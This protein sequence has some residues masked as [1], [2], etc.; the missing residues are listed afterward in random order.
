MSGKWATREFCIAGLVQKSEGKSI[1]HAVSHM[2][3]WMVAVSPCNSCSILNEV[4]GKMDT[5]GELPLRFIH[6][7][8]GQRQQ[9]VCTADPR[10][11]PV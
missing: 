11:N 1:L 8:L 9:V 6:G 5:T 4:G 10:D 2:L 3:Q 7:P